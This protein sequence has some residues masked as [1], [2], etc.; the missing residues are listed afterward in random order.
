MSGTLTI[1]GKAVTTR[2]GETVL[3]CALRND[4]SIPH[5]CTHPNLPPF[6]ACRMCLVE[7]DGMRGYP[8]SCSTPVAEGM[9]VRTNTDAVRRLRR[10]TLELILLEHPSAC[11]VCD[12]RELCERYRPKAEKAGCTTGCHT[13]NNKEVCEIRVLSEQLNLAALPVA[14][15]YREMPIERSDP[16]IDR[17][18]NLCILCGRCI[19]ICEAHHDEATI[20]FVG[21][22]SKTRIGQAFGRSLVDAGCRFCG[23][24]ID[25]C[26]TGS[27]SDRYAKWRGKPD[28]V[29][30]TTCIFCEA[31][32]ALSV[33]S[34]RGRISGAKALRG[35][36]PICVLGRFA[37]PEFVNGVTRLT[38]PRVRVGE[39][40]REMP[41]E[42]ALEITARKLKQFTGNSFALVC[43][44]TSTLED[45]HLFKR[46][47]REV[48]GSAHYIEIEPDG[49]GVSRARLPDGVKAALL[50]GTF[51]ESAELDRLDFLIVQ[52]CYPTAISEQADV[53]LPAAVFAEVDGTV[54]DGD[55]HV[56]PLRQAGKPPGRARAEWRIVTGLAGAMGAK[57]FDFESAADITRELG[58][59]EAELSPEREAAPAAAANP[60]N[61]RTHFR[62]HRIDERV[63][64]LPFLPMDNGAVPVTAAGG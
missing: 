47:V 32:C 30:E 23:S 63:R 36:V 22:G 1:D 50:T 27:L 35:G 62:G 60:G 53:V 48:M 55:G 9:R 40:L 58:T 34:T 15:S 41:W 10:K 26:P 46:F 44:T 31:A 57:G 8:A 56:R 28:A 45:R 3:Q 21:R 29:V 59:A 64:G 19:R 51:V 25:V 54:V 4:I 5:L 42:E 52:D 39:V 38:V 2:D 12:K 37:L 11:L 61:R 33:S 14:P 43:D 7:I 49:R 17:D 13:C 16:F 6:G 20:A 18:L 24:C